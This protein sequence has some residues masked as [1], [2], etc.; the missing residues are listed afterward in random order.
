ML[1]MIIA[2]STLLFGILNGIYF[3]SRQCLWKPV[4]LDQAGGSR[5]LD[6]RIFGYLRLVVG[7]YALCIAIQHFLE[8]QFV[9]KYYTVW[10]WYLLCT[11]FITAGVCS[12]K[13]ASKADR[14]QSSNGKTTQQQISNQS[15]ENGFQKQK[16][17]NPTIQKEDEYELRMVQNDV[18]QRNQHNDVKN[19]LYMNQE[20]EIKNELQSNSTNHN[21][22][23]HDDKQTQKLN[24]NKSSPQYNTTIETKL[25][26]FVCMTLHIFL[27]ALPIIDL[28]FWFVLVPYLTA[29]KDPEKLKYFNKICFAFSSYNMHGINSILL[30]GDLFLNNINFSWHWMGWVACWSAFYGIWLQINHAMTGRWLYFFLDYSKPGGYVLYVA[31]LIAHY[32]CYLFVY[33]VFYVRSYFVKEK[34]SVQLTKKV[35]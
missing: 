3:V 17:Q 19:R 15:Q 23:T 26:Q 34:A 12:L 20:D 27:T 29:L 28:V 4:N 16:K 21:N 10:N 8:F 5:V 33:W 18:T 9:V 35:K 22:T 7:I 6:T 11:Y 24:P 1:G 31:L 32:M 14:L 30:L 2:Y 13:L 25:S